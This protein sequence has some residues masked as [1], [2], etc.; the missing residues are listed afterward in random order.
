M[1]YEFENRIT[2]THGK[3]Q[4]DETPFELEPKVT[5]T[6]YTDHLILHGNGYSTSDAA[7]YAG[8][9]WRQ[10]LSATFAKLNVGADFDAVPLPDRY[11]N[12]RPE[13]PEARG[14]HVFPTPTGLSVA[15]SLGF[16]GVM[17]QPLDT[18]LTEYLSAV[19]QS[20]PNG[21]SPRL[22]LA[23]STFH[24]ALGTTNAEIKYVRFVTA[25][26][27]LIDEKSKPA[28]IL[29]AIAALREHVK[30][31][32]EYADVQNQLDNLLAGDKKESINQIGA[33]LASQHLNGTY[34]DKTP[35]DF[36]KAVYDGRS[37]IL[38]GAFANTGKDKRPTPTE[39]AAANVELRRFVLDLLIAVSTTQPTAE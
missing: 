7:F 27:A 11:E 13:A 9:L 30:Q 33:Q 15:P 4:A 37:R 8:K 10:H 14:L 31:A 6:N 32:P 34:G 18:V 26:E 39:I 24:T 38:H 21:L 17:N 5:L 1:S 25:I 22:E 12:D 2:I 19:R 29:K 36:F 35:A 3:L 20:L 23:Y 16:V 28:P